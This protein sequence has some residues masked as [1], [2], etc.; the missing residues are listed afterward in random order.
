MIRTMQ[1]TEV[2]PLAK[3]I[4][5]IHEEN[6]VNAIFMP[7]D[8]L[9]NPIEVKEGRITVDSSNKTSYY[10]VT[11]EVVIYEKTELDRLLIRT[12][13][14]D[15]QELVQCSVKR[16]KRELSSIDRIYAMDKF[17]KELTLLWDSEDE[18]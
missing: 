17:T 12:K 14:G 11:R 3:V 15:Y 7:A 13:R 18:D 8:T 4:Q 9:S 2:V 5:Y 10:Y 16:A 1:R 6:I